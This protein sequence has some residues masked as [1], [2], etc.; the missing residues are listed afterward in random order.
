MVKYRKIV[1]FLLALVL[2]LSVGMQAS[3][4][5]YDFIADEADILSAEEERLLEDAA[6]DASL[7]YGCGIYIVTLRDY[8]EYGSSVRDAAEEYFLAKNFGL[9]GD[10]NGIMLLLSMAERDYALIAHGSLANRAFT[11]YGKDVLSEEFLDDFR[12]DDWFDGFEDYISCGADFLQAESEGTPVDTGRNSGTASVDL[13]WILV[14]V[15]PAGIAGVSCGVMAASM[16]TARVKRNADAYIL[17]KGIR[18]TGQHD[19]FLN[20]TVVRQKIETNSS[21]GTRVNSGG[22][23]GKSGKF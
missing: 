17:Q 21:G 18:I 2:L 10:Q 22:F 5:E 14:L 13:T 19:R 4:S 1:I 8:S 16:K 12:Y 3:A 7:H 15:I 11:D 6:G 20:R 9:G 23:S